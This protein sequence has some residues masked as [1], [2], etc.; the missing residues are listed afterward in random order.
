MI[1]D[2]AS[3]MSYAIFL[4][5]DPEVTDQNLGRSTF[6][7]DR[8]VYRESIWE[9]SLC[10]VVFLSGWSFWSPDWFGFGWDG[11]G[12]ILMDGDGMWMKGE[13]S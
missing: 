3:M 2:S 7:W 1:P 6:L 12:G 4:G 5:P 10:F 11:G 9:R 8:F 13:S